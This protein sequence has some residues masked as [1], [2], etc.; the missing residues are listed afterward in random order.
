MSGRVRVASPR[1]LLLQTTP[2]A[3]LILIARGVRA[4][5]DG[6]VSVLLPL[7]LTTVGLPA[8]QVGLITTATLLGSAMLTLLAGALADRWKRHDLLVRASLLMIF[9]GVG[10]AVADDFWPLLAVAFVGTMNPTAGD[11]SVFLPTEQSLLSVTVAPEHRTA[12]FARYTL[13]GVLVAAVGALA[14][15]IPDLLTSILPMSLSR[16]LDAMFVLYAALGVVTLAINHRLSE[17]VEPPADAPPSRLG[18]SRRAVYQ[19][20]AVFSLDA[21]AGGFTMNAI[22]A[23]WLFLRFDLATSTAGLIFF[24]AGLLSAGSQLVAPMLAQRIGL[25]NTMV[26]THLPA[27]VF[28]LLT[29]FM[30]NV[31]LAVACLLGRFALAQ[32]DIPA[33]T[34]YVMA[35]VTPPERPAAAS[36]TNVPRSLAPA[37]SPTFAG[38]LLGMTT[39][40]WPLVIGASLKIVYDLLLLAMFRHRSP[41][42][43]QHR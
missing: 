5:G 22:I 29:P 32:M 15:G 21:F 24:W 9:T 6:F 2:D 28:L 11:V 34:S 38:K 36:I 18:S 8:G 37:V 4:F 26:F 42:E 39:F 30:P 19:M 31:E 23:F 25:I 16:A 35:V 10:F 1:L 43:E 14:A 40:G 33:R 17:D 27:N 12:L 13:I 3:R 20:A 41:P 7:H